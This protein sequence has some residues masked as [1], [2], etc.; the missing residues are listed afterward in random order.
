MEGIL[1]EIDWRACGRAL[2]ATGVSANLW[3]NLRAAGGLAKLAG[4]WVASAPAE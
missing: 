2:R 1:G 4:A 3:P